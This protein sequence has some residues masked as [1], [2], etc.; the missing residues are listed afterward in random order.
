[1]V[2]ENERWDVNDWRRAVVLRYASVAGEKRLPFPKGRG[3]CPVCDGLLIAKCGP[4]NTH[5]WAH[6]NRDDCDS[7]SEPIGPWHLWWQNLVRQE[8]VE[9]PRGPHRADIVGNGGTVVE[10]QHSPISAED[11]QA[12]EAHYGN[13]LWLFDATQRFAYMISGE[14]AFFAV[15]QTKHLDLCTKPVFLDFGFD[16]VEVEHFTD[17]I[18]LVSGCGLARSRKWF[19]EALLSDVRRPG[20]TVDDPFVPEGKAA[21]PWGAKSPVWKLKHDT[22]WIDPTS[23]RTVTYRKWTEYIQVSYYHYRVGDSQN[24]WWDHDMLIDRHP[25]IAN[26]WTKDG[27]RQMKEFFKG[28]TVILG[29]LLRLLPATLTKMERTVSSTE[30]FLRLAEDH[31][32]AGRLPLLEES[33][34][35]RFI[36]LA[37]QYEM[38]QYGRPIRREPQQEASKTVEQKSLF[39]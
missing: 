33:D 4:I 8:A 31:V 5:H 12:R 18:T 10:L 27:V 38:R 3:V 24:K 2:V 20:S 7:W 16:V 35:R 19:A 37:K 28:P 34:K 13:M 21:Y 23:G 22:K 30:Y 29:G 39:D 14:R 26:G 6:E 15:G 32:R 11:I 9:V 1:M 25:E 17:A 36:D